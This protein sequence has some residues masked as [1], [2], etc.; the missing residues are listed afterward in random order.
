M[1]AFSCT[2]QFWAL[3]ALLLVFISCR[4]SNDQAPSIEYGPI[5]QTYKL[6]DVPGVIYYVSPDGDAT[7]DGLAPDS[8]T[9]IEEAFTRV[10]TGDAIIMR[11][12]IYRTGNLTFNQK[13]S[14]G[15][16]PGVK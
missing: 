2:I 15:L 5:A 8:P 13:N 6:P 4:Q 16:C 14:S 12:G 7:A 10:V 11:G 1:K 3:F 9:A